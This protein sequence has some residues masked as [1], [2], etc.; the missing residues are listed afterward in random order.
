M[1][2]STCGQSV[3]HS[4]DC[5]I[6]LGILVGREIVPVFRWEVHRLVQSDFICDSHSLKIH[7]HTNQKLSIA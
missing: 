5:F 2:R 7:L 6:V 3:C 4:S 1:V